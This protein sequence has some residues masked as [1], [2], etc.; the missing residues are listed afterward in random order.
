MPTIPNSGRGLNF[1]VARGPLI[2]IA[3]TDEG[4]GEP[5][6]MIRRLPRNSL[7]IFRH[8]TDPERERLAR[9]VILACRQAG[10]RCLVAGD[11]RLARKCKADGVH[12]PE[13]QLSRLAVR[14]FMPTRWVTTGAA[15]GLKSVKQIE[16]LGLDAA[17][18]SP[19]FAS[20]SHPGA[21]PLGIGRFAAISRRAG[22]P[23]AALGGVNHLQVRRLQLAGASAIAGISLFSGHSNQ[24]GL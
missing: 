9:R 17:L 16:K 4:R 12:F 8:Y 21:R 11:S 15:H 18:L 22:V 6:E 1:A 3:M 23:V 19:V 2:F 7:L 20:D 24:P 14:R 10:V 13:F 5:F